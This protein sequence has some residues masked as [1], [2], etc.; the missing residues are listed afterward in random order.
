MLKLPFQ[1]RI[2][3][4]KLA[5]RIARLFKVLEEKD[6]GAVVVVDRVNTFY[7]TGFKALEGSAALLLPDEASKL[8]VP[9]LEYDRAVEEVGG[10]VEVIP[11]YKFSYP[12]SLPREPIVKSLEEILAGEIL[13][14]K[15]KKV[16]LELS[17]T[18]YTLVEKL[19]SKIENVELVDV[20][21]A[22]Q[23]LR[24]VKEDGEVELVKKAARISDLSLREGVRDLE[25][26]VS[27][28]EIAGK[29]E[30][31][32]KRLGAE[33]AAFPTIV[34]F[35]ENSA[36]PHATPSL[37]RKL[38][39]GDIVL[40]DYGARFKGYCSDST[41][42]MNYGKVGGREKDMFYAVLE[43]QKS[44]LKKAGPNVKC[45]DVDLEARRVLE[46]YGYAKHYIHST[47]HGV[48]LEVHEPP[49]LAKGSEDVLKP[50]MIVTVEPGVYVR[51]L[52]G[53]RIEDLV[54]ITG[55][56]IEVLS[57][58]EKDLLV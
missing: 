12:W 15:V 3:G 4:V 8:Y 32:M 20:T 52:G 40:V 33:G 36:L 46:E 18:P 22:I 7:F 31:S 11:Y 38:K 53:V 50:G 44:A 2:R 10:G 28:L 27:E 26:G 42:T 56:G 9:P 34:A 19:K 49:R 5:S 30:Y 25:E 14:K 16:G 51:G 54:L 23:E 24:V 45:E 17:K 57:S 13:E 43:A 41:R 48:G 58:F 55:S 47:G 6:V 29:I 21:S 1:N 37:E 39:S 35:G